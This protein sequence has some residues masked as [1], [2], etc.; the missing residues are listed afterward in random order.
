MEARQRIFYFQNG[1]NEVL[2]CLQWQKC[3]EL[4]NRF[5]IDYFVTKNRG[6]LV[7]KK[8]ISVYEKPFVRLQSFPAKIEVVKESIRQFESWLASP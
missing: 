1:I 7:C 8:Y 3:F 2:V 5:A 6:H 4:L